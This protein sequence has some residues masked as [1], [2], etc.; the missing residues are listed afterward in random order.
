M[1]NE[2]DRNEIEKD[3]KSF[4]RMSRDNFQ[5]ESSRI[6]NKKTKRAPFCFV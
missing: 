6:L 3:N 1:T 4:E 2:Y 5:E